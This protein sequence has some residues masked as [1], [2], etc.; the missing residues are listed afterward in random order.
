MSSLLYAVSTL[1]TNRT[2]NHH[3]GL[4]HARTPQRLEGNV[5]AAGV[6]SKRLFGGMGYLIRGEGPGMEGRNIL[7][8]TPDAEPALV[9]AIRAKGGLDYIGALWMKVW[10]CG[11][12]SSC[13]SLS[14]THHKQSS[15]TATMSRARRSGTP[16]SRMPSA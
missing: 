4:A 10:M 11:W 6:P 16:P 1:I 15:R 8:D 9:E 7:I 13:C 3:T 12:M 14:H 2:L 5:Y